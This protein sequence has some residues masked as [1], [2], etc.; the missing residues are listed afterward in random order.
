MNRWKTG[1][2]LRQYILINL[3]TCQ[4]IDTH[5]WRRRS[6]GVNIHMRQFEP[7]WHQG[8][9][10]IRKFI[11]FNMTSLKWMLEQ[12][13]T[14]IRFSKYDQLIIIWIKLWIW[15]QSKVGYVS[16]SKCAPQKYDQYMI[17]TCST[18]GYEVI[19]FGSVI[20]IDMKFNVAKMIMWFYLIHRSCEQLMVM[21]LCA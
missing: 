5:V 13:L 6:I 2:N 12:I 9:F 17:S 4:F 1:F 15:S 20:H 10:V 11:R 16:K 8:R 21:L 7:Q 18:M 19:C 14:M 3:Y